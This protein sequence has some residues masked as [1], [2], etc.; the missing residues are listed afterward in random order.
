MPVADYKTY[1]KM[2]DRALEDKFAYSAI[3]VTSL[4]SAN[5]V[6]KGLAESRSDGII[7]V[8]T[9]GGASLEFLLGKKLPGLIALN[10]SFRKFKR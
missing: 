3:N 5:A 4:A 1:C 8:S 7:Q 6:L 2:L 10:R 9:G